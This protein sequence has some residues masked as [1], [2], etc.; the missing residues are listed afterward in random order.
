[1]KVRIPCSVRNV[2]GNVANYHLR[3]S[4][5]LAGHG[6]G[7]RSAALLPFPRAASPCLPASGAGHD[8]WSRTISRS[9]DSGSLPCVR[10]DRCPMR[11]ASKIVLGRAGR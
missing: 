2:R 9:S 3:F 11:S 8:M 7:L 1:M 4:S 6:A 10:P 5:E